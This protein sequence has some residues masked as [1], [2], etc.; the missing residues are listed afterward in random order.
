MSE[1]QRDTD[2][3]TRAEPIDRPSEGLAAAGDPV[4]EAEAAP[5]RS[6][7]EIVL[8]VMLLLVLLLIA[9]ATGRGLLIRPGAAGGSGAAV[10]PL[11][12]RISQNRPESESGNG[13]NVNAGQQPVCSPPGGPQQISSRFRPHYDQYG[14]LEIFGRPISPELLISGRPSQWFERA[15]LEF[16]SE[17]APP[18]DIQG[19]LLGVIFTRGIVFPKQTP[20][21]SRPGLRYFAETSHGVR[22]PFLSFWEQR[23]GLMIFGYPISDEVQER[24]PED[25]PNQTHTVQYFE[26]VRLELHIE[27]SAPVIRI[28][29]L[30]SA[31]CLADSKPNITNL[32]QPTPVPVP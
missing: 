6:P 27:Q 7:R 8:L 26:R 21:V 15:L 23:G 19:E 12:T 31:L 5:F 1:R 22:E 25:L 4:I 20:F 24:L 3:E 29:L 30:G 14:G 2:T 11:P 10:Q 9:V 17:H 28:G 32:L 13:A 18:Y 16:W